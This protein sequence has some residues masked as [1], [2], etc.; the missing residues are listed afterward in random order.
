MV[1]ARTGLPNVGYLAFLTAATGGKWDWDKF[2]SVPIT[3]PELDALRI[4][5]APAAPPRPNIPAFASCLP[6]PPWVEGGHS[7]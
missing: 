3:G 2:E 7:V 4:Q 6:K 1:A 5:A